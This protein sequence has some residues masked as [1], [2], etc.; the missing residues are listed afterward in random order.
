MIDH[1]GK[2][3]WSKLA[4]YKEIEDNLMKV[5]SQKFGFQYPFSQDVKD[6]DELM[7]QIEWDNFMVRTKNDLHILS[8]PKE[9]FLNRF[10]ELSN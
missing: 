4:N 7:L 10:R 3:G 1:N 2:N 6:V 9:I 5:I 8:K